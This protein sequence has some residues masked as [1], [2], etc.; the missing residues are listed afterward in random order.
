LTIKLFEIWQHW[1]VTYSLIKRI[2]YKYNSKSLAAVVH[3]NKSNA[4]GN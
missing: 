1:A 4:A 2:S 3:I